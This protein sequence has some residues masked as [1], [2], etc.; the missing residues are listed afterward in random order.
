MAEFDNFRKADG[1]TR[2]Q[3]NGARMGAKGVWVIERLL[4]VVRQTFERGLAAVRRMRRK[5][6]LR[7]EGME[8]VTSSSLTVNVGS[9]GVETDRGSRPAVPT[10]TC[11]TAVM[12][13]RMTISGENGGI[14]TSEGYMYSDS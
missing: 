2:R 3:P 7:G 5:T 1:E 13:W 4:P 11:I 6:F 12:L 10:R 8:K 14:G 9:C